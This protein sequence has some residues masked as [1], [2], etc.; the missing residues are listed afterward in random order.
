LLRLQLLLFFF[1]VCFRL[2][3]GVLPHAL[4]IVLVFELFARP[5]LAPFA[6]A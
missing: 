6:V 1:F 5:P 3:C 4:Q 2:L